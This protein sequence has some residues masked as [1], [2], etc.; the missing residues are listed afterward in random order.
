MVGPSGSSSVGAWLATVGRELDG[1][2][3]DLEYSVR[4]RPGGMLTTGRA[5]CWSDQSPRTGPAVRRLLKQLGAPPE[6]LARSCA[7]VRQGIGIDATGPEPAYRVYVH[8]R[9]P[10]TLMPEYRSWAWTPGGGQATPRCYSFSYLPETPEGV[11]PADLV[12]DEL[13]PMLSDVLAD[14][15]LRHCSG[16]WL[17]TTPA[18]VIDQVDLAFPWHPAAGSIPGLAAL[19]RHLGAGDEA[20]WQELPVRHVAF[21]LPPAPAAITLYVRGPASPAG[22]WPAGEPELQA[23]ARQGAAEVGRRIRLSVTD[24]LPSP[25]STGPGSP[26]Q[27]LG[28]FYDGDVAT[29]RHVLGPRMHYHHGLFDDQLAPDMDAALDRAVTELYPFIPAGGRLYDIGCGWGGALRM[30]V[31]D[32]R[33]PSLGLT[34]SRTQY[35][36]VAACGLPVRWGDAERTLPPGRFDCAVMLESFEH[37]RAKRQLLGTLR[38]FAGRLVMRVNCQDLAPPSSVFGGTMHMISSASLRTLLEDAGWRIEH[39]KDRRAEAMPSAAVWHSRV[40]KPGLVRDL[41]LDTLETWSRRVVQMPAEWAT[42]N[43]LIEVVAEPR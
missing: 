43:P 38:I 32:L 22:R 10:D 17:R 42:A 23:Q 27:S 30:W 13:R 36:H 9:R 29:W 5:T 21:S 28:G 40:T 31:S 6:A 2:G 24:R 41:H 26:G 37:I 20:G 15:Q 7:G 8:S 1:P 18:G 11:R 12:A 33:C 19:A 3:V 39:W 25:V 35:R 16:F 4:L 14:E 34:I